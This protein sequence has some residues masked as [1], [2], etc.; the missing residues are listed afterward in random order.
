MTDRPGITPSDIEAKFREVQGQFD[1]VAA[2]GKKRLAL[3]G[4]VGGV[5]LVVVVYYLGRRAG[6]RRSTVLEIRRL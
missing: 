3:V 4:A 2:D 6:K 1:E 5:V